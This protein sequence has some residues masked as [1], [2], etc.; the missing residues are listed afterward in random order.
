M[1]L[2]WWLLM[3]SLSAVVMAPTIVPFV[4][5]LVSVLSSA[6]SVRCTVPGCQSGPVLGFCRPGIIN[7]R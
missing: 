4:M 7:A 3:L 5:V 2:V 1:L 6:N